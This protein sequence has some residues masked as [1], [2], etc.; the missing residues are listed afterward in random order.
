MSKS[1]RWLSR[2]PDLDCAIADYTRLAHDYDRDTR[3]IDAVRGAAVARLALRPGEVV[4]D[5]A[6]GTGFCLPALS[7][8][9]GNGGKVI[10]VEPSAIM[11]AQARDRVDKLANVDLVE[12]PAQTAR[13]EAAPDA[14]L[15]SFTHDVLQSHVALRN[16]LAQ[17]KFGARVVAVGSKLFPWWL[18]PRNLWFL[19]GERGYVTTYRGFSRPWRL[20]A[21]HLDGFAVR[22]LAPG[23]KYMATG[24]VL[25]PP[26]FVGKADEVERSTCSKACP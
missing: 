5:I 20:L 7:R 9:V 10:G 14:L 25:N 11:M 24:R 16:V 13:L 12:A 22:P 17:A 3:W 19:A 15:F 4:A 8:A 1:R 21:R 2:T 26:R 18:A 23:N 6:C